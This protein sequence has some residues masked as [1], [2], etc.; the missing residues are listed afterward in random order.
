[1]EKVPSPV[2]SHAENECRRKIRCSEIFSPSASAFE[3]KKKSHFYSTKVPI[4]QKKKKKHKQAVTE[5]IH[6]NN[7][8]PSNLVEIRIAEV[9]FCLFLVEALSKWQLCSHPSPSHAAIPECI[10]TV[11]ALEPEKRR[12]QMQGKV[13]CRMPNSSADR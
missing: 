5:A 3:Q 1:M 10:R 12:Q 9:I 8:S 13:S 7:A 6:K 2:K 11:Q 4:H